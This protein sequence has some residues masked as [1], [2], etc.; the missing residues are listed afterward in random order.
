MIHQSI[1]VLLMLCMVAIH[2]EYRCN[3]NNGASCYWTYCGTTQ[4]NLGDV[5]EEG[6]KLVSW[7]KELTHAQ[8]CTNPGAMGLS[9]HPPGNCCDAYGGTCALLG[10]YKRLWCKP[11]PVTYRKLGNCPDNQHRI[12]QILASEE[13]WDICSK[14]QF[15]FQGYKFAATI[16]I[17]F[18]M[19]VSHR[20]YQCYEI[21]VS[22]ILL[23]SIR[24]VKTTKTDKKI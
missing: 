20:G 23:N 8:I 21:N 15:Q 5:D 18:I 24:V 4:N 9:I 19:L 14:D 16:F 13:K 22:N 2:A 11:A 10:Q 6:Y 3:G 7:T 1:L 17:L 12:C